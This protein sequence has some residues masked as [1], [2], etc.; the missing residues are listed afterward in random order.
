MTRS[1]RGNRFFFQKGG[2][3]DWRE[4]Y[5]R[6]N[7]AGKASSRENAGIF[8]RKLKTRRVGFGL[9]SA[10]LAPSPSLFSFFFFFFLTGTHSTS[11]ISVEIKRVKKKQPRRNREDDPD[12]LSLLRLQPSGPPSPPLPPSLLLFHASPPRANSTLLA[13]LI[14]NGISGISLAMTS[15]RSTSSSKGSTYPYHWL[16][17]G[18]IS[19]ISSGRRS[20][21]STI[22]VLDLC[23]FTS[24]ASFF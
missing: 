13:D 15:F 1:C 2:G 8:E 14:N 11:Y 16:S 19:A 5:R 9:P 22:H 20:A 21:V 7:Q 17:K 10:S 18:E 24:F 23:T 6:K 4:K 12:R 3:E